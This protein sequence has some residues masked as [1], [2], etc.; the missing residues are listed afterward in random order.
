MPELQRHLV[1]LLA[2][3]SNIYTSDSRRD[4][5]Y[6]ATD[7]NC[8]SVKNE[9]LLGRVTSGCNNDA[10]SCGLWFAKSSIPNSGLG[11]Y[12]GRNFDKGEHMMVSGDIVIPIV[13]MEMHQEIIDLSWDSYTWDLK[14]HDNDGLK[15]V[16]CL[17]GLRISG[18]SFSDLHN[19][20]EMKIDHSL[21]GLQRTGAGAFTLS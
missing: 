9:D 17:S 13:D 2:L 18:H 6:S 14:R 10:T 5:L 19:V 21:V 1:L 7:G 15:G 3:F 16:F 4:L 12:A 8:A 20:D 11:M